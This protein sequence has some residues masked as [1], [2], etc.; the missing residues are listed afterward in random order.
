MSLVE[1]QSRINFLHYI[2]G[3]L[4]YKFYSVV[5]YSYKYLN[6]LFLQKLLL[7][8][9]F[10]TNIHCA[11]YFKFLII[12]TSGELHYV[13]L[14]NSILVTCRRYSFHFGKDLKKNNPFYSF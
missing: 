5:K 9:S 6:F 7:S 14:S 3:I 11:L 10:Y 13:S 8:Y 2:I 12:L 4:L 1:S